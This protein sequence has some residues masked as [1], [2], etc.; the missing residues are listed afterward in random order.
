MK[1]RIPPND[2]TRWCEIPQDFL[3]LEFAIVPTI[4]KENAIANMILRKHE[5]DLEMNL[6]ASPFFTTRDLHICSVLVVLF[7][8][9]RISEKPRRA[10]YWQRIL[11]GLVLRQ[12]RD[13]HRAN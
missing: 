9:R 3:D 7:L 10:V 11:Q 8:T 4:S 5:K 13:T 6:S 12:H 2:R 1:Q